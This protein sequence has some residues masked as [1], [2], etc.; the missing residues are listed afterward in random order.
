[1]NDI[2]RFRILLVIACWLACFASHA[3]TPE[4]ITAA[5]TLLG[6]TAPSDVPARCARLVATAPEKGRVAVAA[7]VGQAVA[8]VHPKMVVQTISAIAHRAPGAAPAAAAAAA[9][10]L[11]G[12]AA[13]IAGA[14][15]AVP[16]VEA[17]E[18]ISAV[19]VAV[20]SK[21]REIESAVDSAL[22][23]SAR[24]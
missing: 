24:R 6:K 19:T 2:S 13:A 11:P 7:A 15:A 16:G 10:E 18:V 21:V 17:K 9:G 14:A 23:A 8:G 3:Q 5:R 4:Q 20:P 1:M 12:L 22:A